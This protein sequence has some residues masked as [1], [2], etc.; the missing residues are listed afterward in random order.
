MER[1]KV[2]YT[3][4]KSIKENKWILWRNTEGRYSCGCYRVYTGDTKKEVQEKLKE[5]KGSDKQ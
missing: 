3:I 1:K 4:E 2:Y 5:L